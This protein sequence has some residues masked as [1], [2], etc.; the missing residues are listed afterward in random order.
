MRAAETGGWNVCRGPGAG[1]GT[2]EEHLESKE[3]LDAMG[4]WVSK[5]GT[6]CRCE[7]NTGPSGPTRD[8]FVLRDM[9]DH[10]SFNP[11]IHHLYLNSHQIWLIFCFYFFPISYILSYLILDLILIVIPYVTS[12]CKIHLKSGN[13]SSYIYFDQLYYTLIRSLFLANTIW[14]TNNFLLVRCERTS[15]RYTHARVHT[16]THTHFY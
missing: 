12:P 10:L 4:Q 6:R 7:R 9:A 13:K 2:P 1:E 11:L 14:L 3:G 8:S 15:C 5:T 16:H